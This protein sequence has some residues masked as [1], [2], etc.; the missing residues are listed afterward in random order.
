MG[1]AVRSMFCA[2]VIL[3]H[4]GW[5]RRSGVD[6]EEARHHF[7]GHGDAER[8]LDPFGVDRS[9]ESCVIASQH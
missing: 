2:M 8:E 3:L 9:A 1:F 4:D 7:G 5:L 6:L